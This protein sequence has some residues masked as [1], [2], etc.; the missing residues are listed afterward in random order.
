MITSFDT[1]SLFAATSLAFPSFFG[2]GLATALSV[3]PAS[4]FLGGGGRADLS[5][6]PLEAELWEDFDEE[7]DEES[8]PELDCDPESDEEEELLFAGGMASL[9]S[10]PKKSSITIKTSRL[11]STG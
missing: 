9:V 4:D 6:D 3:F 1:A 2:A 11:L 8:E 5:E 10:V 7:L